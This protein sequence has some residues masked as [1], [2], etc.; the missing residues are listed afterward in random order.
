MAGSFGT[1]TGLHAIADKIGG[2]QPSG[3]VFKNRVAVKHYSDYPSDEQKHNL[4]TSRI[5]RLRGL[6]PGINSGNGVDSYERY[7]YIHGTNHEE[8]IG[9][10]FSKGCIEMLN[11]DVIHLFNIIDERDLICIHSD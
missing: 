10:P 1:P 11:V 2:A 7:I 4:I 3:M 6:E 9:Q 8:R 5:I